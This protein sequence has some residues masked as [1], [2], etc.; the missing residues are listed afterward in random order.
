MTCRVGAQS[1]VF[2]DEM[3]SG[4]HRLPER[5]SEAVMTG[6]TAGSVDHDAE[7]RSVLPSYQWRNHETSGLASEVISVAFPRSLSSTQ[8]FPL[9]GR[10]YPP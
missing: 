2:L 9:E 3:V 1:Y 4:G 7:E 6:S 8:R 10:I 5:P